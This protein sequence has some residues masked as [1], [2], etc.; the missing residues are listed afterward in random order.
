M[1]IYNIISTFAQIPPALMMLSQHHL[2]WLGHVLRRSPQELMHISLF[3][4]PCDGWRQ[5]EED[6]SRAELKDF[7]RVRGPAIYGLRW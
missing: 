6:Q 2:R 1:I 3:A 5:S 7:E 4:K